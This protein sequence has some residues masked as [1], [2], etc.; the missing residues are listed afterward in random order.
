MTHRDS[1]ASTPARSQVVPSACLTLAA[2]ACSH[3]SSTAGATAALIRFSI[4]LTLPTD[5]R[6]PSSSH[7]KRHRLAPAQVVH[8]RE[9]HHRAR[10]PGAK[11]RTRDFVVVVRRPRPVSTRRA[12][13][14]V[15]PAPPCQSPCGVGRQSALFFQALRSPPPLFPSPDLPRP[16]NR[17]SAV[18]IAANELWKP[19]DV[20]HAFGGAPPE[21]GRGASPERALTGMVLRKRLVRRCPVETRRRLVW[22]RI[23]S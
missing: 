17:F 9:Q 20:L 10:Q 8:A 6:T 7:N 1:A 14:A 15:A 18:A 11:R 21:L 4:P 5:I 13:H 22:I 16:S 19:E 3:A 23:G 12:G 2:L